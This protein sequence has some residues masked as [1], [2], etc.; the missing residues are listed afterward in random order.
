M[1]SAGRLA[2]VGLLAG[3]HTGLDRLIW[4]ASLLAPPLLRIALAVP[5]FRSGLTKWDGFLSL[6]PSAAYLFEEEFKLHLFGGTYGFPMPATVAFVDG[7]AEIVLPILLVVGLATRLSALGVLVMTGVIQLVVPEGW[8]N[9]H[10]PWAALAVGIIS[11]GPG[12][13]SLDYLIARLLGRSDKTIER[14]P[15]PPPTAV[16]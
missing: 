16:R 12:Y 10:L 2:P 9:F 13:L 11:V 8:A 5:F 1:T 7:L 15:R 6:A 4:L 14:R 3:I